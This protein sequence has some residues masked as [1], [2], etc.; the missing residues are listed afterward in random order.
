MEKS[1]LN[2]SLFLVRKRIQGCPKKCRQRE[3]LSKFDVPVERA[4]E[5]RGRPTAVEMRAIETQQGHVMD[6]ARGPAPLAEGG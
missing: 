4:F 1:C 2:W 6:E 3:V 5:G